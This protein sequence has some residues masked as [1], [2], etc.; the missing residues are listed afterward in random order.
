VGDEAAGDRGVVGGF[1]PELGHDSAIL[2]QRLS[3]P[4]RDGALRDLLLGE[5]G[6]KGGSALDDFVRMSDVAHVLAEQV[7]E[8]VCVPGL[9]SL[10]VSLDEPPGTCDRLIAHAGHY[11]TSQPLRWNML[12]GSRSVRMRPLRY[13]INVTL[14]GCCD[15]RA[16]SPDEEL[17]LH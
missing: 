9:P 3:H 1:D 15:H 14:D 12:A 8:S 10:A 16:M 4:N 7:E 2:D 13:S 11:S 17:H 5:I 6:A